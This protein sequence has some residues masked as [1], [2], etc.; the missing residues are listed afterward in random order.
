MNPPVETLILNSIK[1]KQNPFYT[2]KVI[3][4]KL[5]VFSHYDT[6]ASNLSDLF[7]SYN[8]ESSRSLIFNECG[9]ASF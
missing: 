6:K 8:L 9:N 3:I 7:I 4:G 5:T 1:C 2:K